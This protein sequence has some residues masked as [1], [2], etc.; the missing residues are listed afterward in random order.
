MKDSLKKNS[1]KYTPLFED[2]R[3]KGW[4]ICSLIVIIVGARGSTYIP[5]L[6]IL[7]QEYRIKDIP[8]Y[9]TFININTISIQYLI[10]IILHKRRL[11]IINNSQKFT[12]HPEQQNNV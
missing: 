9:K 4:R 8:L 1:N 2:I 3:N 6:D 7:K 5:L 11:K 10:S 12:Y